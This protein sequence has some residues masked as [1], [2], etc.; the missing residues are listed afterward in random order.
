MS[1][2]VDQAASRTRRRNKQLEAG[3]AKSLALEQLELA[4]LAFGLNAAPGCDECGA[5]GCS[6]LLETAGEGLDG[7]RTPHGRA[8]SSQRSKLATAAVPTVG[9]A[10][11]RLRTMVVNRRA[12]LVARAVSGCL[13]DPCDDGCLPGCQG[14]RRVS[15]LERC[16]NAAVKPRRRRT[17]RKFARRGR[18]KPHSESS[19]AN[20]VA[21]AGRL[22][23][24]KS[25]TPVARTGQEHDPHEP[26][27]CPVQ[28]GD[29]RL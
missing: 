24:L 17:E 1:Y 22:Q 27:S 5:Y 21:I 15:G 13:P 2:F 3:A 16:R 18:L 8:S 7:A 10:S 14:R 29:G 9:R 20:H 23:V 12:R 11:P 6:V 4:D 28:P 26:P 25:G 19:F